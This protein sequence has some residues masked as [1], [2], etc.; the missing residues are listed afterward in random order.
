MGFAVGLFGFHLVRAFLSFLNLDVH[1][2]RF[3]KFSTITSS[4]KLSAPLFSLLLILFGTPV[5]YTQLFS[6]ICNLS[7]CDFSYLWSIAVWKQMILPLMYHH[8][9]SS[10]LMLHHNALIIHLTSSHH[11]NILSSHIIT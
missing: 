4:N 1:F 10:T 9:V 11:I 7:F 3:G 2:L 5:M 8:Q 6:I